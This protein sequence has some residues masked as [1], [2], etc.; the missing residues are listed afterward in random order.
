[1]ATYTIRDPFAGTM[2]VEGETLEEAVTL[3]YEDIPPEERPTF[4]W[5]GRE[6]VAVPG[7]QCSPVQ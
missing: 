7:G 4:V 1:M 2:E 3:A 6:Q 5:H